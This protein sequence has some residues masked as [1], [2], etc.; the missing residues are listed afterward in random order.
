MNILALDVGGTAV[1]YAYFLDEQ[2]IFER[3]IPSEARL[4]GP[5]LVEKIKCIIR[6]CLLECKPDAIGISMTGQID[7]RKGTVIYSND[8]IPNFTGTRLKD[9]LEECFLLPVCVENDVNT[10]AIGELIYGAGTGCSDFLMLTYGTGIGGAIVINRKLYKGANQV[11]AE[12]GHILTHPGG[13]R[14]GCGALGCYEMYGSTTALVKRA[15]ALNPSFDSG[16]HIFEAF[17][18]NNIELKHLIDDW[19]TEISYGLISLVHTF[20]PSCIILGGG[21]MEQPYI[22]EHLSEILYQNIIPCFRD[23]KL[24]CAKLGNLAGVYGIK[25]VCS[26]AYLQE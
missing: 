14:C 26:G 15:L 24:I 9:I 3:S 20:N 4:G 6:S 23:V 2:L 18:H 19:I 16:K 13:I 21:I 7:A 11:A 25:A 10:A 5:L 12:F 17:S 1:K 22:Q 8:N